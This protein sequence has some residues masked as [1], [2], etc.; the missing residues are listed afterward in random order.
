[1]TKETNYTLDS[2]VKDNSIVEDMIKDAMGDTV[3]TI[4]RV[5][6]EPFAEGEYKEMLKNDLIGYTLVSDG[7]VKRALH[8]KLAQMIDKEEQ[9][10]K[11]KYTRIKKMNEI[12][13]AQN[14]L[15][16]LYHEMFPDDYIDKWLAE[17]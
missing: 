17:E 13:A 7:F 11:R 12:K 9:E 6:V 15:A 4:I 2:E 1:M 16:E 10:E 3:G 14:V 5:T 8:R